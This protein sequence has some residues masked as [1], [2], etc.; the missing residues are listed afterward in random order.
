[1]DKNFAIFLFGLLMLVLFGWY[2]F[3]DSER[4]KRNLGTLLTILLTA[5]CVWEAYPPFDRK[6]ADGK[7]IGERGKI[8]L[9]L[10]LQGGTSFLIRLDPPLEDN[11]KKKEITKDMVEQAMEAIRK[12]V[13]SLGV[14]EPI[15]TPQGTD[16]ILVQIP[17]LRQETINEARE[18]L[19]K[20]AKLEFH[21]VH[22]GSRA[23]APAIEAGAQVPPVGYSLLDETIERSGKPV[24]AKLLI[25]NKADLLGSNVTHAYPF[26]DQQG[27]GVSLEFNSEGAVQFQKLTQQV[28]QER[29]QMAILLDGK[30]QSAPS[31]DP[32]KYPTGI[33]GGRAQ[34]SGG[35]MS[36]KE[37]RGLASALQNPLQT[38][39]AIEEERSASS[40]LGQDAIK[41]GILA[42]IGGLVLVLLFVVIYYRFAGLVA[43]V[44]L[45][46]NIIVL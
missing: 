46:V 31:V 14:S 34:I 42:G 21:L 3:T 22:P 26:F 19:R 30:I 38:P 17:G 33:T 41:S 28:A 7:P 25:K 10:D 6:D 8:H 18:Q 23:L 15:I 12:R 27:W 9:G 5:F 36:E 13:D 39:V 40:T 11:G 1:M 2:F 4:V 35:S 24:T 16:R 29:S 44:G 45:V 43:V 32:E 20:V 37:A